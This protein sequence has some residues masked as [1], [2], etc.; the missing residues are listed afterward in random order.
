MLKIVYTLYVCYIIIHRQPPFRLRPATHSFLSTFS[1]LQF[2]LF[3]QM[4]SCTQPCCMEEQGFVLLLFIVFF[5]DFFYAINLFFKQAA[6]C[7]FQHFVRFHSVC[8]IVVDIFLSFVLLFI[9][10]LLLPCN[11]KYSQLLDNIFVFLLQH[12]VCVFCFFSLFIFP[13]ITFDKL[14]VEYISTVI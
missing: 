12:R 14:I 9:V 6:L 4:Y 1:L 13:F 8:S 5:V 3:N 2:W 10:F 7:L 11:M